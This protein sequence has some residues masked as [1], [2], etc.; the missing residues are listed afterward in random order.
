MT[1]EYL[2]SEMESSLSYFKNILLRIKVQLC[3]STLGDHIEPYVI[4]GLREL[5][6]TFALM[7]TIKNYEHNKNIKDTGPKGPSQNTASG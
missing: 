5:D 1:K 6:V 4:E 2:I 3:G 7:E